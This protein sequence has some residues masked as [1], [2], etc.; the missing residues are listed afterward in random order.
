[1]TSH[2][3]RVPVQKVFFSYLDTRLDCMQFCQLYCLEC[4]TLNIMYKKF[5]GE[6]YEM[7][8]D[9]IKIKPYVSAAILKAV[10]STILLIFSPLLTI[11]YQS[12]FFS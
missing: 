5:A 7:P 4:N 11:R 9:V 6:E 12:L 2:I 10:T 1:M 3:N 8:Q